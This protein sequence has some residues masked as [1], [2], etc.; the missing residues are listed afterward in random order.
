MTM[1]NSEGTAITKQW[2]DGFVGNTSIFANINESEGIPIPR[3]IIQ[4]Y[5]KDYYKQLE[6]NLNSLNVSTTSSIG[7]STTKDHHH[8]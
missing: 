6:G 8:Q 5:G 7:N 3:D 2:I 1:T 4:D